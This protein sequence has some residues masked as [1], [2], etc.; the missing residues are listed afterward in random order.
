MTLPTYVVAGSFNP[1]HLGHQH[2]IDKA[3][4]LHHSKVVVIQAANPDKKAPCDVTRIIRSI[5]G[6]SVEVLRL[7]PGTLLGDYVVGNY[8]YPILVRGHRSQQDFE[9]EDALAKVSE[10][11]GL[12]TTLFES[13]AELKSCSSSLVRAITGPGN[14]GFHNM[15]RPHLPEPAYMAYLESWILEQ[16]S[17]WTERVGRD[18]LE[19]TLL[20]YQEPHRSYHNLEHLAHTVQEMKRLKMSRNVEFTPLQFSILAK[21]LFF[22][23]AVYDPL[24][25]DN[26]AQSAKLMG[27]VEFDA[28]STSLILATASHQSKNILEEAMIACDLAILG[29][30]EAEYKRYAQGIRQEYSSIPLNVYC[31]ERVRILN[32]LVTYRFPKYWPDP[33]YTRRLVENV[34]AEIL[35]LQNLSGSLG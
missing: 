15:I 33:C 8:K 31:R 32:K 26:E 13:P 12:S 27:Q 2:L 18:K 24:S 28:L 4:Q 17:G 10:A 9:Y 6:H 30:P 5:Y 3:L 23:D 11:Q 34:G 35:L 22:H 20:K 14:V 16:M 7:P 29:R 1:F 21:A 25:S 19:T